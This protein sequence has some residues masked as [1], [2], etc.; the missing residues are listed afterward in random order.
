MLY[1]VI[2]KS[3]FRR[4]ILKMGILEESNKKQEGVAHRSARLFHFNKEK[5]GEMIKKGFNFEM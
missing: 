4:K 1:E 3:N 5:Y 2:T